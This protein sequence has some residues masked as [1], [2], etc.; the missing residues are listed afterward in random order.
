M[1]KTHCQ[2]ELKELRAE[3]HFLKG[4]QLKYFLL[5]V[6][7]TGAVAGFG[8]KVQNGLGEAVFLAPLLIALPCWWIFFD[9]AT[10]I[11]RIVGYYRLLEAFSISDGFGK[12]HFIGWENSLRLC[13]EVQRSKRLWEK[14]K[15]YFAGVLHG[16]VVLFPLRT[17]QRYWVINWLTFAALGTTCLLLS[18][19]SCGEKWELAWQVL[20]VLFILSAIHNLSVLGRLVKGEYSYSHSFNLW[21]GVLQDSKASCFFQSELGI[22]VEKW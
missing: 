12:L 10:S 20:G 1:P 17:T 21:K 16:A 9:K 5:S 14:I 11:T 4:C 19:P 22:Q 2:I 6:G 3:L 13:R 18:R 8:S 7:A 15:G